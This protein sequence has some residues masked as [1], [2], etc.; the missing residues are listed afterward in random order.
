MPWDPARLVPS[1]ER[2]LFSGIMLRSEGDHSVTSSAE[3]YRVVR[4]LW[5]ANPK[6]VKANKISK[7]SV[8]VY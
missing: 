8:L 7:H 4:E 2:D 3:L 1:I 5:N 6:V